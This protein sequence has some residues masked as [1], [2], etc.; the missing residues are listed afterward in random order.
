MLD[1][2]SVGSDCDTTSTATWCPNRAQPTLIISRAKYIQQIEADSRH[3]SAY[4]KKIVI[5]VPRTLRQSTSL[6]GV[7]T[8]YAHHT[9]GPITIRPIDDRRVF[10]KEKPKE[11]DTN[12]NLRQTSLKVP[13]HPHHPQI[14][15]QGSRHQ[16]NP[17]IR[18]A[19]ENR[20]R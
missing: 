14:A 10:Q 8:S 12:Q 16:P 6:E 20:T 15:F 17:C 3:W 5:R 19:A 11:P 18:Y 1:E 13:Y 2:I 4:R 9:V 7:N